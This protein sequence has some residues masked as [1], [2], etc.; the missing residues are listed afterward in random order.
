MTQIKQIKNKRLM[1]FLLVAVFVL[2]ILLAKIMIDSGLARAL[3]TEKYGISIEPPFDLSSNEKLRPLAENGL[4]PSEWLGLY[5]NVGSCEK[6]CRE[7]VTA[8]QSIKKVLGKDYDRFKVGL[9]SSQ[10]STSRELGELVAL[11]G[12]ISE[13]KELINVLD[14]RIDI[15]EGQT[16]DNGVVLIDWR[17]YMMLYYPE[18]DLNGF[19]KDISKLLR[20]SRIR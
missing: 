8:L 10:M 5:F 16:L 2:P 14:N 1:L 20:G 6:V 4:L 11:V 17:G 3:P 15:K 9:F 19:K 7:R 13:V 12:G 18:L